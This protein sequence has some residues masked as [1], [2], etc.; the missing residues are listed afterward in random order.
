MY[1]A[2][3]DQI[4]GRGRADGIAECCID[5]FIATIDEG[6]FPAR[7]RGSLPNHSGVYVPCQPCL[8]CAGSIAATA[9]QRE[10]QV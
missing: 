6:R 5:A 3:D 10:E 4:R 2:S 1:W 7:D 8:D 9:Q